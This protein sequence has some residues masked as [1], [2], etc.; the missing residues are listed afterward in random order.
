METGSIII[1]GIVF[2]LIIVILVMCI[3]FL[4][5]VSIKLGMSTDCRNYL[6]LMENNSGLSNEDVNNLESKLAARGLIN[7]TVTAPGTAKQGDQMTLDVEADYTYRRLTS[8]FVSS[9]ITQHMS[10]VKTTMARKVV[11]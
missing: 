5:P 6:L 3:Q 10:Y 8:L 2:V 9:K 1:S 7:I 11:N 4:L